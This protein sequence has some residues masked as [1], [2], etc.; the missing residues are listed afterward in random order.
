MA[1]FAPPLSEFLTR[2]ECETCLC[3]L[4]SKNFSL[5]ETNSLH[6][7]CMETF[8]WRFG[9]STSLLFTL[10]HS[11][12]DNVPKI[13]AGC[14]EQ[15]R[16]LTTTSDQELGAHDKG[17]LK[18]LA[19][20]LERLLNNEST[21]G[22]IQIGAYK[23]ALRSKQ[24]EWSKAVLEEGPYKCCAEDC[25]YETISTADFINHSNDHYNFKPMVGEFCRLCGKWQETR[26][27]QH[28]HLFEY[29]FAVLY[30]ENDQL[31]LY[32]PSTDYNLE[33]ISRAKRDMPKFFLSGDSETSNL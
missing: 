19:P 32:I 24:S 6:P 10:S 22:K 7:L 8:F 15:Y 27:A 1:T 18:R 31:I 33:L 3:Y 5:S 13:I 23:H 9:A 14:Q 21:K 25:D 11:S 28:Y 4:L 20:Y 17:K 30:G 12:P 26:I 29:H 16:N 2:K